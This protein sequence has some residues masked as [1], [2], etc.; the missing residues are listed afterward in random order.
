MYNPVLFIILKIK[1]RGKKE[2]R[3]IANNQDELNLPTHITFL[4][5][6]IRDL[7]NVGQK[8]V[9]NFFDGNEFSIELER[10][11]SSNKVVKFIDIFWNVKTKELTIKPVTGET[12][13]IG[14]VVVSRVHKT[15]V[16]N[17]M[18]DFWL[19]FTPLQRRLVKEVK[20][21][22][23][24]NCFEIDIATQNIWGHSNRNHHYLFWNFDKFLKGCYP[25][26]F[27]D[28]GGFKS[29]LREKDDRIKSFLCNRFSLETIPVT[30]TEIEKLYLSLFEE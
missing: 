11:E 4:Q 1:K 22:L 19:K 24:L 29:L 6:L 27:L 9:D 23:L 13:Y 18:N 30:D 5:G 12:Y 21:V 20:N 25:M 28:V 3:L 7:E 14:N 10:F 2:A 26:Q 16:K 15:T 8:D 17:M